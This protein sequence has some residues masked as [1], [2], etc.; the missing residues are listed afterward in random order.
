MHHCHNILLLMESIKKMKKSILLHEKQAD[1]K[2][3]KI[4]CLLVKHL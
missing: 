1:R 2:K 3:K 4:F